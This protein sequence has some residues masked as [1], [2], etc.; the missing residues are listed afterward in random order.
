MSVIRV[1][2]LAAIGVLAAAG[3]SNAATGP[4]LT[5]SSGVINP[6][7]DSRFPEL[8]GEFRSSHAVCARLSLHSRVSGNLFHRAMNPTGSWGFGLAGLANV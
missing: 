3:M 7:D 5:A 6:Y 8:R 2:A 1:A 4:A